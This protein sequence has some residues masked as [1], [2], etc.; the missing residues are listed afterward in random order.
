MFI[1][2]SSRKHLMPK[3][4]VWGVRNGSATRSWCPNRWSVGPPPRASWNPRRGNGVRL[5]VSGTQ[6][7]KMKLQSTDTH[8]CACESFPN[9]Q[10]D[11]LNCY[12]I[13]HLEIS[14][15]Y[16]KA[17]YLWP[18]DLVNFL[19]TGPKPWSFGHSCYSAPQPREVRASA[20]PAV[21]S[22]QVCHNL[23]N[24]VTHVPSMPNQYI[25]KI[26]DLFVPSH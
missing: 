21:C 2:K 13:S 10:I 9:F 6:L 17:F 16:F 11:H 4:A 18:I 1:K 19:S 3:S 8:V 14:S 5:T 20:Q 22:I 24:I 15:R 23:V 25:S 12:S 26:F 7:L